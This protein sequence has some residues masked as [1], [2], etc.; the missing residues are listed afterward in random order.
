MAG[1]STAS[2]F[3]SHMALEQ[4]AD[5]LFREEL[6]REH[7]LGKEA[8]EAGGGLWVLGNSRL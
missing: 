2:A 7:G 3:A 5:M 8:P 1:V 4:D 6:A